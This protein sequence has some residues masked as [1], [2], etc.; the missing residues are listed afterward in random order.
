VD[1]R[2]SFEQGIAFRSPPNWSP[3]PSCQMCPLVLHILSIRFEKCLLMYNSDSM[4]RCM[5]TRA[6]TPHCG[7]FCANAA[8]RRA[9][10]C[11]V[12]ARVPSQPLPEPDEQQ[13]QQ[14]RSPEEEHLALADNVNKEWTA[15]CEQMTTATRAARYNVTEK[16]QVVTKELSEQVDTY[17]RLSSDTTR[18]RL[19]LEVGNCA[20]SSKSFRTISDWLQRMAAPLQDADISLQTAETAIIENLLK[21]S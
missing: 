2:L 21:V 10:H 17:R 20:V 13:H 12:S 9:W 3:R 18:Q 6:F 14:Q 11:I 19:W 8:R 1:I 5:M 4:L 16:L 7:P 15:F